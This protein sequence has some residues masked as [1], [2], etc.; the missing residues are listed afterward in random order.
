MLYSAFGQILLRDCA[1]AARREREKPRSVD[2]SMPPRSALQLLLDL[3]ACE[4]PVSAVPV[5]SE[6][7]MIGNS[8]QAMVIANVFG[9]RV[10]YTL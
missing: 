8:E 9:L 4:W 1:R 2:L 5:A 3:S 7:S 10:R 6:P